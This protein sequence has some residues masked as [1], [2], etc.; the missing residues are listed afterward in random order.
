MIRKK[1]AWICDDEPQILEILTK[2]LEA[3][4]ITEV[5]TF[6][7]AAGLLKELN[8][9][10]WI[11]DVV[12]LDI[13]MDGAIDAETGT[14]IHTAHP[15]V[16]LV[17]ITGHPE[18]TPEIFDSAPVY[19]LKKPISTD[20]LK[21][22]LKAAEAAR[23]KAAGAILTVQTRGAIYRVP[24]DEVEYIESDRRKLRLHGLRGPVEWYGKLSETARQ[25][26]DYFAQPHQSYLVNMKRI[27]KVIPGQVI[28]RSGTVIPT[29]QHRAKTFRTAFIWYITHPQSGT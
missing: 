17:Y 9:C 14:V 10:R 13:V 3:E 16:P 5:K 28:M 27:D 23:D 25:L 24:V 20:K 1:K 7:S 2:M 8:H 6:A 22:A 4:G 29:S 21:A 26:P 18:Y 19:L 12:F 15:T 11:P